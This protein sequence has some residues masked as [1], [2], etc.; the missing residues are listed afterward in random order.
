MYQVPVRA[1][2]NTGILNQKILYGAII[3]RPEKIHMQE[4]DINLAFSGIAPVSKNPLTSFP[5]TLCS[6]TQRYILS[7]DLRKHEAAK[8]KKT[9]PGSPG[10][11]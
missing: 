4:T 8:I 9:V 1:R 3:D 2:I 10:N 6:V 7:F 5:N 11:I